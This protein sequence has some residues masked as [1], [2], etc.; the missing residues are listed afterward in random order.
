MIP[1][2]LVAELR[3]RPFPGLRIHLCDGTV[4]EVRHPELVMVG[5]GAAVI[6]TPDKNQPVLVYSTY[7]V[8]N[9]DQITRVEPLTPASPTA[10]SN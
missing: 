6:G 4:Y 7:D 10:T 2:E 8:I 9:L 3:K 1:A 5:V